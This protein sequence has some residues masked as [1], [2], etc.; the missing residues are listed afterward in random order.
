MNIA[1]V[2]PK[3]YPCHSGGLEVFNYYLIKELAKQGHTIW[4]ITRCDYEWA[5]KNIHCVKLRGFPQNANI[6]TINLSIT[7]KLIKLSNEIDIVHVPYTSN[8]HVA[9][10]ILFFHK[11][12]NI[13]Y[14][15]TIHGGGMYEW[16]RKL[17]QQLFFDNAAIII[18]VSEVIKEEYEKRSGKKII[19]IP[20][21]IPFTELKNPKNE[22][23]KKYSFT[24]EDKILLSLGSIKKIKGS[25]ILLNA[26]L[27][28]GREYIK[29]NNLKL[30]FVGD[31]PMRQEL[32]IKVNKNNL[33]DYVKFYGNVTRE[34]VPE[35]YKLAD[36]YIISSLLEGTPISLLEAKYN[37]LP[38]I[39]ANVKGINTLITHYK[40]GLLFEKE[41]SDDLKNKII[42]LVNDPDKANI[43][44][45]SAKNDY[46]HGYKYEDMI[47]DHINIYKRFT[48]R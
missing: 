4:I 19:I 31:G 16:K 38:I 43:L 21:L 39:G 26:F 15:I 41:N 6:H 40:N 17:P 9:Y 48:K 5:D 13:P 20:P 11:L 36:I 37:G 32:E 28:L 25:D 44:G 10:P 46:S 1:F 42:E 12:S 2:S 7:H 27:N 14:I 18:A 22:I 34:K 30:L 3:M 35:M 45:D 23:K 33:Q 47:S 8:S 29:E 24:F